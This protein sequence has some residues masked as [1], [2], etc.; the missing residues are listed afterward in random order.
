MI[1]VIRKRSYGYTVIN[2]LYNHRIVLHWSFFGKVTKEEVD[3]LTE[4][5]IHEIEG[6][7]A[8]LVPLS[9]G[10]RCTKCPDCIL[11]TYQIVDHFREHHSCVLV[12]SASKNG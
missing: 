1:R 12:K 10:Y 2:I 6:Y 11:F 3:G 4:P 9:T 8:Y 5:Y 7:V